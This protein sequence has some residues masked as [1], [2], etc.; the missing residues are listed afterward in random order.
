[1][2]AR[3]SD[4]KPWPMKWVLVAIL[5]CIIPYT[6]VMFHYRKPGPAFR[7][8]EDSKNRANVVRLLDTG[9]RRFVVPAQRNADPA[10][11]RLAGPAASVV[12]APGGLPVL[13]GETLVE[14]PLMPE[15]VVFVSAT[16]RVRTDQPYTLQFTCSVPDTKEQLAG[17]ELYLREQE[18]VLIPTFER[19]PGDLQAR[20]R[21]SLVQIEIPPGTFQPGTYSAALIGS[22]ES[23]RWT[24]VVEQ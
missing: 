17:A 21:E 3:S 13:L 18:L 23:Q 22:R 1:M 24:L 6:W 19:V 9:F 7:P 14:I 12:A 4:K 8:Y 2:P 11:F 16:Q 20:S 5:V 15:R 10:L